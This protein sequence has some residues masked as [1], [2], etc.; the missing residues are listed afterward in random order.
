MERQQVGDQAGESSL[1]DVNLNYQGIAGALQSVDIALRDLYKQVAV[2]NATDA[3]ERLRY[4]KSLMPD[5]APWAAK[6][7]S[8]CRNM[9]RAATQDK[10]TPVGRMLSK[11][12][13]Q[14]RSWQQ[15][16]KDYGNPFDYSCSAADRLASAEKIIEKTGSS[17]R[18][19]NGLQ[20]VGKGLL[21]LNV[22]LAV[23]QIGEGVLKQGTK[24]AD[25]GK[26]D[27]GEGSANAALAVGTYI[28]TKK[29]WLTAA[30]GWA[31]LGA[32][33]LAFAS[34]SLAAEEA[35]RS[36]RGEKT[37]IVEASDFYTDLY[38]QSGKQGGVSGRAKQVGAVVGGFFA[39]PLAWLQTAG[40]MK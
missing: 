33:I 28:A 23:W 24:D 6:A 13:E 16:I 36:V 22:I 2:V 11:Y 21:V 26:V 40:D 30:G 17:S 37:M 20:K 14:D 39:W 10:L 29:G 5:D 4:T 19:M 8:D 15:I 3:L 1:K 34:V 31:G 25:E 27:I 32:S 9:L 12:L 7:L 35:R 18:R 38:S